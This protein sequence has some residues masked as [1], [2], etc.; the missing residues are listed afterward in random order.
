[1]FIAKFGQNE[2]GFFTVDT[3]VFD[4]GASH[5]MTPNL[6]NLNQ[7]VQYNGDEK[8]NIGNGE[9]LI[10]KHIGSTTLFTPQHLLFLKNILHVLTIIV[11]LLSIRKLR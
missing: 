9:G 2:Q 8:V 5:C 6:G 1:M 10:V 3:W 11:N 4:I 7:P